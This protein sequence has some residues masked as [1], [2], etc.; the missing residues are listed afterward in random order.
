MAH[1]EHFVC[2]PAQLGG[3]QQT[4]LEKDGIAD[5]LPL[6]GD[7]FVTGKTL[8]QFQVRQRFRT[9]VAGLLE[10]RQ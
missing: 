10:V 5:F 6:A 9:S 4:L 8:R 1:L 2:R 3:V 7:S